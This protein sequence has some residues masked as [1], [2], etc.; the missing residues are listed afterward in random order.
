M[1]KHFKEEERAKKE[2]ERAKR[3]EGRRRCTP[4]SSAGKLI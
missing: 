1:G 3:E 4:P 2:E